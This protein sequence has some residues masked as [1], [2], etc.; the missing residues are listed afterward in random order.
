[1]KEKNSYLLIP[2]SRGNCVV[3][4]PGVKRMRSRAKLSLQ[5]CVS[6]SG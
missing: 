2:S 1:M 3:I 5:Q 4:I 6:R